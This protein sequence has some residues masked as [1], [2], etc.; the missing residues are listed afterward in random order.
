MSNKVEKLQELNEKLIQA[1]DAPLYTYRTEHEYVPV[2]GDGNPNASILIVGEAPGKNEA[3][4]GK[5]FCGRAGKVLD[6]LLESIG[7]ERSSVYIT[8]I[9]KDRPQKNRDPLP[10]EIAWYA[11]YLDQQIDIIK[12]KVIVTLGRFSMEYLFS[13]YGVDQEEKTIS[14]LHGTVHEATT[15]ETKVY[16]V[17]LYHPAAC[18]YNQKLKETLLEDMQQLKQFM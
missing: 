17:A 13:R 15:G 3:E 8:N 6:E 7:L 10:E 9:V 18:I 12:P 16:I 11:P 4:T 14:Q 1:T 5:P 2:L